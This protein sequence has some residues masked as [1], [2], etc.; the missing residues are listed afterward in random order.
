VGLHGVLGAGVDPGTGEGGCVLAAR[1]R[2]GGL[3]GSRPW[4]RGLGKGEGRAWERELG[5]AR[6]QEREKGRGRE[7]AAAGLGATENAT[8]LLGPLVGLRVRVSFFFFV[9]FFSNFKIYF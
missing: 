9:Y 8:G 5:G 4:R 6:S 7:V 3:A 1:L 2:V